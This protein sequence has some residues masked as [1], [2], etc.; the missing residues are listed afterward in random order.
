MFVKLFGS[1]LDSSI[2]G[3]DND[4]RILWITMLVM[5]DANGVVR[6]STSGL[7]R[8][9]HVSE[10]AFRRSIKILESPDL[11][12]KNQ[13][14]GGRRVEK[15]DGGWMVLNY[16]KYREIRTMTQLRDAERQQRKRDRERDAS[17]D[18]TDITTIASASA[19]PSGS[20]VASASSD[21]DAEAIV[22]HA[23]RPEAEEGA[24]LRRIA[25]VLAETDP[26]AKQYLEKGTTDA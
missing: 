15:V 14:Y 8:R 3:E 10:E 12:S 13:D 26:R 17:R 6:A 1:I 21:A 9:A 24:G 7:V 19:S 16:K 22:A 11:D 4:T 18:V 20:G 2:W 23:K 5:A 25:Q